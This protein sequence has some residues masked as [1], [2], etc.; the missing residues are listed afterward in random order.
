MHI[1]TKWVEAFPSQ[2]ESSLK[3][4]KVLHKDIIPRNGFPRSLQSD[5]GPAFTSQIT[6]AITRALGITSHLFTSWRPQS[7]GKVEKAN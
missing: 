1:F 5:N 3:V 4:T 6:Q 7:S 2:K